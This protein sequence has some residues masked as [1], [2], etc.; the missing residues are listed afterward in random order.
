MVAAGCKLRHLL[1]TI[2]L[3]RAP[4]LLGMLVAHMMMTMPSYHF[5]GELDLVEMF[6][7][8]QAVSEAFRAVGGKVAS[9]DIKYGP[10]ADINSD[11]GFLHHLHMVLKL[12][13]DFA[14][15]LMAPVCSTWV[16]TT[17]M[18]QGTIL[19]GKPM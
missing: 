19:K 10:H 17:G 14:V 7:G 18:W 4:C 11:L 3:V 13:E 16:R 5:T 2:R 1:K 15:A 6:A 8:K 12:K 9:L